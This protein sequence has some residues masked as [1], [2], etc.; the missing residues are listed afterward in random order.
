MI[1]KAIKRKILMI[2]SV[3]LIFGCSGNKFKD[4]DLINSFT[5]GFFGYDDSKCIQKYEP[6]F[7]KAY[8]NGKYPSRICSRYQRYTC[9]VNHYCPNLPTSSER[10]KC[11][12]DANDYWL[13]PWRDAKTKELLNK[14]TATKEI[15]DSES[16]KNTQPIK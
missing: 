14:V 11:E 10:K 16:S 2:F 9:H 1:N 8:P 3:F 6:Q 13:R 7:L 5:F 12:Q 4:S 15:C